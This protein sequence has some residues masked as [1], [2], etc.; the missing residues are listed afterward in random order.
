MTEDQIKH[1]VNRFLG[2]KIP[3]P[4][5][6]DNGISFEPV[7]SKGTQY[8][9]QRDPSGTNLFSATE[10]DAMVRYMLDGLPDALDGGAVSK[11]KPWT[12]DQAHAAN[13]WADCACNGLQWLRNIRD[14]I[15]NVEDAIA[16]MEQGYKHC[17]DIQAQANAALRTPP[18]QPSSERDLA[19]IKFARAAEA[20]MYV[21]NVVRLDEDVLAAFLAAQQEKNN[22][23]E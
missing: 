20:A 7:G 9:F 13:E 5:R 6:P 4:F 11:D 14:G 21:A 15:S 22:E 10:A 2:W 3:L 1:M 23:A 12:P 19:L 8:E 17:E 18:Q 16:N